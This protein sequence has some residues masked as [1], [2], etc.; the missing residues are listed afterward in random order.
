MCK[1]FC[2]VRVHRP[3]WFSLKPVLCCLLFFIDKIIYIEIAKKE[4]DSWFTFVSFASHLLHICFTFLFTTVILFFQLTTWIWNQKFFFYYWFQS[5]IRYQIFPKCN[6]VFFDRD[7]YFSTC[8]GVYILTVFLV[9]YGTLS[10]YRI[11][12]V[13]PATLFLMAV[14]QVV[15]KL[16]SSPP[17]KDRNM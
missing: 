9:L 17:Q 15:S 5:R 8:I 7:H 6:F 1:K 13:I 12:Y 11:S 14:P 2:K 3:Y 4:N 10:T 16:K